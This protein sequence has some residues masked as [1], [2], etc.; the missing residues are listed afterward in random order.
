MTGVRKL[1]VADAETD[2]RLDRWFK[3]H[4]PDLGHGRLEKLLRS[5]Q[6]RVEGRRVASGTRLSAGQEVRIPPLEDIDSGAL[7]SGVRGRTAA[8]R[9]DPEDAEALRRAVLFRDHSVLAINKA[10]GM[11][12]QGGTKQV[13]HLDALL[14]AVRFEAPERPRLVHRL[15]KDTSGVLLLARNSL[16]ARRLSEIFKG[17]EARKTYW[18]LVVGLP[19]PP[20]GR[21][22]LALAKQDRGGGEKVAVGARDGKF[23][24]TLYGVVE[25]RGPVAWLVLMPLTG[26]THQLRAH[27]AAQ[28]W[29]IA[30]DGKYGGALAFPEGLAAR[31]GATR[32]MLHAREIALPHPEDGTTLRVTA[33]LPPHMARAFESLGFDPK[34][35]ERI[36]EGLLNYGHGHAHSPPRARPGPRDG[37]PRKRPRP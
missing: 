13:R 37:L 2:L 12:V 14:E 5:G 1:T 3:R 16:A 20:R 6:I 4:F 30:G 10:P 11:A 32:L 8:P 17:R 22:D 36:A 29:P 19:R 27:C 34:A 26:R 7:N 15:D 33:P 21:I 35:G 9:L 23:A 28:G 31:L 25:T 18:A 24:V